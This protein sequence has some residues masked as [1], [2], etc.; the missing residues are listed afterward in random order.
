MDPNQRGVVSRVPQRVREV[1]VAIAQ[2]EP[3]VD[4]SELAA[5]VGRLPAEERCPAWRAGGGSTEGLPE[6]QTL[7]G[8]SLYVRRGDRVTVGLHVAAHVVRANVEDVWPFRHRALLSGDKTRCSGMP[9]VRESGLQLWPRRR[10]AAPCALR[11]AGFVVE[12]H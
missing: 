1:L 8:Q 4:Q 6:H 9:T 12:L 7:V 5:A 3:T 10:G 11:W 2:L